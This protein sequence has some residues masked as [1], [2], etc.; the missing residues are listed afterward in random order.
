MECVFYERRL[1]SQASVATNASPCFVY[2]FRRLLRVT[3]SFRAIFRDVSIIRERLQCEK[4]TVCRPITAI[5]NIERVNEKGDKYQ[6]AEHR[7]LH[8]FSSPK[9]V[10]SVS[11]RC[12]RAHV[13][14]YS[15]IS[16]A[17]AAVDNI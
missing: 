4:G 8:L 15:Q 16:P 17:A 9:Y 12:V 2:I 3:N 1:L 6:R 7:V 14:Q 11:Y 10:F 5:F 13:S